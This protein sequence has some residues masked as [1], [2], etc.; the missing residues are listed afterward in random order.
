M[1]VFFCWIALSV[2][3]Y[4]MYVVAY[5][6]ESRVPSFTKFDERHVPIWRKQSRAFLPG[7]LGLALFIAAAT[8]KWPSWWSGVLGIAACF[9]TLWALRNLT[10]N[11]DDYTRAEWNSWSKRYHDYVISFLFAFTAVTWWFPIIIRQEDIRSTLLV[12]ALI[13]LAIWIGGVVYDLIVKQVP[14]EWQH[15]KHARPIWQTS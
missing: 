8:P 11:K 15:P 12:T 14:N 1:D 2:V 10:Y 7:D 3:A 4:G 9:I 13:G 6:L 5:L